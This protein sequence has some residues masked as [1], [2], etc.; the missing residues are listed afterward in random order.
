MQ[1]L[2]VPPSPTLVKSNALNNDDDDADDAA[3]VNLIDWRWCGASVVD[4][5]DVV[6]MVNVDAHQKFY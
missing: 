3:G 2:N 1:T 4:G 6:A 5:V